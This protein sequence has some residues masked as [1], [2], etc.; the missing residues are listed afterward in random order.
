LLHFVRHNH[1]KH[2]EQII[3]ISNVFLLGNTIFSGFKCICFA[4]YP[5]IQKQ[6]DQNSLR[7][8]DSHNPVFDSVICYRKNSCF[9][10]INLSYTGIESCSL[11]VIFERD[12]LQVLI[13]ITDQINE[14]NREY[15]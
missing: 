14:R 6:L 9:F 11:T 15:G 2:I 1:Y 12:R 10:H 3:F 5:D 4:A 8:S 13:E 7:V